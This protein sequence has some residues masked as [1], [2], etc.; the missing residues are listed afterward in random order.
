MFLQ[1]S[2]RSKGLTADDIHGIASL[3]A[4]AKELDL[5][6]N[7]IDKL[8]RGFPM[9]LQALDLSTNKFTN[10]AGFENLRNIRMLILQHNKI[11]R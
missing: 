7:A 10:L 11:T 6:D 3:L 2:F 4:N 1:L 8:S 5:S 9:S